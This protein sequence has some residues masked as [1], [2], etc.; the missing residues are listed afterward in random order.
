MV[1]DQEV[2]KEYWR[3]IVQ[4]HLKMNLEDV[5]IIVDGRS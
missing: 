4:K 3:E 1:A 5:W 2:Y